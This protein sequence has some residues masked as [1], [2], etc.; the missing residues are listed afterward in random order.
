MH[1][2]FESIRLFQLLAEMLIQLLFDAHQAAARTLR[3]L[4]GQPHRRPIH[5]GPRQNRNQDSPVFQ[6][7]AGIKLR[8]QQAFSCQ[9]MPDLLR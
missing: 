6:F 7:A 8:R 3:D 5:L 1:G 2:Q 9:V 4:P